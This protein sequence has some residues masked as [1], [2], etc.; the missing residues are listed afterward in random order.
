[1]EEK[2]Y[3]IVASPYYLERLGSCTI[4]SVT[5]R[6]RKDKFDKGEPIEVTKK[7]LDIIKG[8]QW[9]NLYKKEVKDGS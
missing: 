4:T 7:E 5:D 9:C 8:R 2:T 1:M 3:K 6:K